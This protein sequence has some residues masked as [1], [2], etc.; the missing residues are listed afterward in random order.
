MVRITGVKVNEE[1]TVYMKFG[2]VHSLAGVFNFEEV[3]EKKF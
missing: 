2:R 3:H 1:K